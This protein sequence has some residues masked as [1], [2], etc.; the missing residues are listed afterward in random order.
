MKTNFESQV[1]GDL[2]ID[3]N[4]DFN[5]STISDKD[6]IRGVLNHPVKESSDKEDDDDP[7]VVEMKKP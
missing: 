4:I 6:I 7:G 2:T 3:D 5:Q 1:D